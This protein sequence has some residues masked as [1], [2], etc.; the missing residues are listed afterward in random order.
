MGYYLVV[1]A[2]GAASVVT[3]WAAAKAATHGV[4]GAWCKAYATRAAAEAAAAAL[5]APP[6]PA[7]HEVYVDG[8]ALRGRWSGC[9]VWFGAADPRNVARALPP[10]HTS[11]R[12]ELQAVLLALD[13]GAQDAIVYSDNAF[14]V[15]AYQRNWPATFAHPDLMAALRARCGPANVRVVKVAGHAGVAG[16]EAA[17]R[18]VAALRPP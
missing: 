1:R 15:Q 2:D 18:L 3:S 12:A 11:P 14:V 9:A 7:A 13:C 8:S 10:P 16:N 6:A 4:K 5:A 17:D